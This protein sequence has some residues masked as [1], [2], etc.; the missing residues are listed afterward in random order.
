MLE[1]RAYDINEMQSVLF[2]SSGHAVMCVRESALPVKISDWAAGKL[3]GQTTPG[4]DLDMRAQA[5]ERVLNR[6][7][8]PGTRNSGQ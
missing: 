2:L 7:T 8:S 3:S 5:L 1:H 4:E 6:F